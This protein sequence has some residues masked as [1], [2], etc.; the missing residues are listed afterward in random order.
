MKNKTQKV[1]VASILAGSL[2]FSACATQSQ[3]GTAV[4]AGG[5][6]VLG[7]A[8]GAAIGGKK[9]AVA[10]AGVGAVAG[11]VTGALIGR[12]MDKQE[13]ELKAKHIEGA[14][15][16]R[17]GNELDVKF[18]SGILFS[19]GKSDLKDQA[20]SD[21]AKFAEVLAEFNKTTVRIEGHT[22]STG[23]KAVN[24]KLS[25]S[26][27]DAVVSYLGTH[28]VDASRLTSVGLADT[29]PVGD[30]A[31]EAG[32]TANR[33]VEIVIEANEELKR[34]DA[35]AAEEACG[36]RSIQ[37]SKLHEQGLSKK[38]ATG[39]KVGD[40]VILTGLSYV[41]WAWPRTS[42]S[43]WSLPQRAPPGGTE[44]VIHALPPTT[45]PAPM[46]VSPPSIVAF[47]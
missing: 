37:D 38:R 12:Y 1:L 39:I 45:A 34:E 32:R 19:V 15:V 11:G 16:S 41:Q 42:N 40:G 33:R 30:N 31:T 6:G 14:K 9:G 3:T 36:L 20:M 22:D 2:G 46:T 23:S 28:G 44:Y 13:A 5:G 24:E 10:G 29:K 25:K 18:D 21:L 7:A 4:G 43:P 27:A 47:A 8:I 35:A 17:V 26:R